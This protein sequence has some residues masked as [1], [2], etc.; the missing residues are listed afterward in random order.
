M[1]HEAQ[2]RPDG[3]HAYRVRATLD[4]PAPQRSGMKG[5]AR[6][7]GEEVKLGYW[8]MRRPLAAVREFF[9]L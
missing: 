3:T 2:R 6:L 1:A 5:T 7:E 8:V 9:G 4:A